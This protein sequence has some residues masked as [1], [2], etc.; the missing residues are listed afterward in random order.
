MKKEKLRIG[1]LVD[2][3]TI[4]CWA[5]LMLDRIIKSDYAEIS[6][7][8]RKVQSTQQKAPFLKRFFKEWKGI[9]FKLYMRFDLQRYALHPDAFKNRNFKDLVPGPEMVVS[10]LESNGE[11][12]LNSDDIEKIKSHHI[13]VLLKLGFGT[14]AGDVLNSAKHGVWSYYY[15]DY[16]VN[17]G[18]LPGVWEFLEYWDETGVTLQI[19]TND[20]EGDLQL[21]KSYSCTDKYGIHRNRNNYYWKALSL[22]P[23]KLEE[24]HRLGADVFFEKVN[25]VNATP[26]F[27]YNRLYAG[28]RNWELLK[29]LWGNFWTR[30][31]LKVSG[32]FNFQQWILLFAINSEHKISKS[33][34]KFTRI[35]PPKDRFWAD[36]FVWFKDGKY[37][38]FLEELIYKNNRGTI[39]VIEMDEDGKYGPAQSVLEKD[40][41]LSYPFLLEDEGEL[42]MLPET[43]QNGT[44]ELYKCIDFPLKWELQEIVM[45]NIKAVDATIF[46]HDG[47]YW[48]FVNIQENPGASTWDELFLFHSD[49]LLNGNWVSHPTNP[50]VSDVKYARPAGNIFEH[51]GKIFRPAQ[52]CSKHYGYGMQLREIVTLNESEYKER[53]V[54][55]IFPNWEKDLVSTHTLNHKGKLTVIDAVIK[56]RK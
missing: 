10:T 42:Y 28:P 43:K 13:D 24:M 44:I 20:K 36:P 49:S 15:G 18:G 27:Y 14:L 30:V 25:A 40:Y 3:L 31:K 45:D 51:N 38:I 1:L 29:I 5:Y 35:L 16:D 52:N 2:D 4:P 37:Y 23:R 39:S 22:I 6:L 34:V 47:K 17:R 26:F 48:M 19:L 55:S 33:F 46:K 50:I 41:H 54:Q 32:L 9:L 12:Q 56:R 8:V 11:E 21:A 7:V 53:Q